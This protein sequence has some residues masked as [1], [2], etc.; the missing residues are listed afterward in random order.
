MKLSESLLEFSGFNEFMRKLVVLS[1]HGRALAADRQFILARED[2]ECEYNRIDV[3]LRFLTQYGDK[4]NSLRFHMQRIPLLPRLSQTILYATDIFVVKKFVVNF[5]KISRILPVEMAQFF[6]VEFRLE[7]LR[8]ILGDCDVVDGDE[9]FY[10]AD[11]YSEEL[12]LVRG[13]LRQL[14]S[15]EKLQRRALVD[16]ILADTGMDFRFRDFL[17]IAADLARTL[18]R[19]RF[20]IE[21]FDSHNF[22]VRLVLSDEMLSMAAERE[23]LLAKE[24]EEEELVYANISAIIHNYSDALSAYSNAIAVLDLALAKAQMALDFS[25]V[26]PIFVCDSDSTPEV[27]VDTTVE[28]VS[29]QLRVDEGRFLPL[30]WRCETE[31]FRYWPLNIEVL[32]KANIVFGSNMGGKTVVLRSMA[33]FQ[34]LAQMG[35]FVPAKS[36]VTRIFGDV[37]YIGSADNFSS[38]CEQDSNTEAGLSGFGVEISSFSRA[39]ASSGRPHLLLIDE[40][41]RTT[42]S[43]EASALVG[44]VLRALSESSDKVGVV[45][46]HFVDIKDLSAVTC[47]FFRMRG[48]SQ[49]G[50]ASIHS[51]SA[52]GSLDERLQRINGFMEYEVLVENGLVPVRDALSIAEALGFPTDILNHARRTLGE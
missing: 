52:R 37:S 5:F 20:V 43:V 23:L 1:P 51:V 33:F 16:A 19:S 42:N 31:K 8:Q 35:F 45:S 6:E 36:F 9:T 50:V 46:S 15:F 30:L 47:G 26:R 2:L 32:R 25:M 48:L 12:K 27:D 49:Q 34:T 13:D 44:A 11:G 3:A 24:R 18:D 41:A 14:E 10:L 7:E 39:W 29:A 4:T 28:G 38:P 17:V 40:F 21:P 22:V